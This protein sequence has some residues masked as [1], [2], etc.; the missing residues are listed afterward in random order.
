MQ[1]YFCCFWAI[2]ELLCE[3]LFS[4]PG[5]RH[6]TRKTASPCPEKCEVKQGTLRQLGAAWGNSREQPL[7]GMA[8]V[9]VLTR[10][11][12]HGPGVAQHWA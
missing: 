8:L 6:F 4:P 11:P 1:L 9:P 10:R 2:Q 12:A 7:Q 5:M 3:T